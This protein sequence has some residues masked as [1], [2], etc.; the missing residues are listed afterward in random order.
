MRFAQPTAED[1]QALRVLHRVR[2]PLIRGKVKTANQVHVFYQSL[3]SVCPSVM[4]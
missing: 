2:E 4:Q 1:Q 3:G